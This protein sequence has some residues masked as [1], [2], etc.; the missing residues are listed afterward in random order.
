MTALSPAGDSPSRAPGSA[1]CSVLLQRL[2]TLSHAAVGGDTVHQLLAQYVE[3][4]VEATGALRGFVALAEA[5]A[6][7]LV[8]VATAGEGWTDDARKN[9]LAE[10]DGSGTLTSFVATTGKSARVGHVRSKVADYTPFFGDVHSVLAVPIDL[11]PEVRVRGVINLESEHED[12]FT[13]D[14]EAFVA[15][16]ADLAALRLAMDD[17]H[18]REAALVQM[19][20][21]LSVAPDPDALMQRVLAI[22]RE[23][24]RFEDCSLFL[25][26]AAS[27]RLI[28]VATRG[29]A[30]ATQVRKASYAPGEGLTGWVAANGQSVRIRDPKEDTRYKGLHREMEAEEVGAFLAVPIR[31]MAGV[32]GVLRVLRRKSTSPWFPNDFTPADEEVL[33]T[34]ASLVGAAIDNAQLMSRLVQSERL[35]AWGEM[36]AM[37][38]HMIGNRVFAIK[39][40]LNELEFV[41]GKGAGDESLEHLTRRQVTVLIDGMKRGIFRLEEILAEFRDFVRATALSPI[42]LDLTEV[43]RG[44]VDES[45]PK[46]SNVVLATEYDPHPLPVHADP[47]K[48]KRAFA[49]IIENAV[50]FQE[51][52]GG[53]L[54]IATR[55]LKPGEALPAPRMTAGRNGG[56]WAVVTFADAGPGVLE[57]DKD[58]IFRPFFTSRNRGMGLGLAIVKG[59]IEAHHGTIVEVGTPGKGAEFLILLPLWQ[60]G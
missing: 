49:E 23:I 53:S 31:S 56:D 13:D 37:S 36:S 27:Q 40:D 50:T 5:E 18:A 52:T 58:K 44:V 14:D 25:L 8:L 51:Q 24:L 43:V 26:D 29:A 55:R 34:I 15:G 17:L 2:A 54:T 9:R 59:I 45:F 42:A 60:A 33:S 38:S 4:A 6:G 35:A 32:V 28:L 41:I 10:R 16:I 12:A 47:V 48:L 7:G 21:D 57:A 30:L 19:G 3:E 11:E 22:T 1:S 20:K 39:G 46:R